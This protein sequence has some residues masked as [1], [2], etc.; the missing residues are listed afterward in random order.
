MLY[1]HPDYYKFGRQALRSILENTDFPI[2][3]SLEKEQRC[4]LKL[5]PSPRLHLLPFPQKI[6]DNSRAAPFLLKFAALK[7]C[8]NNCETEQIIMLDSDT[9]VV[10]HISSEDVENALEGHGLG[11]VEQT[12]ITGSNMQRRDFLE[13]YQKH[14]L[15]WIEQD[16]S[17]PS[18]ENFRFYN[19]GIVLGQ[20]QEFSRLVKWAFETIARKPGPHQVGEHMIADQDY[21]QFWANNRHPDSCKTLSWAWNHCRYWDTSFPRPEAKILH[22]SNFCLGSGRRLRL[23]ARYFH[24]K[25]QLKRWCCPSRRQTA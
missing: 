15:A 5:Q 14:S 21:F 23:Q 8:L 7:N 13:H 20:K 18:L 16:Q 19:S 4:H 24:L 2:F 11:M 17:P 25:L 12:T 10:S 22:F 3:L 1:G 9:R 6:S